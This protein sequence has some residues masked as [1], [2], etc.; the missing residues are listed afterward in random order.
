MLRKM[1]R[2][3]ASDSARQFTDV[4]VIAVFYERLPRAGVDALAWATA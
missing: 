1:A 2:N 4:H 3:G